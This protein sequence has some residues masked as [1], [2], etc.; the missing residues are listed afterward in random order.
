MRWFMTVPA[1]SGLVAQAGTTGGFTAMVRAAYPM[2]YRPA[3]V[4]FHALQYVGGVPGQRVLISDAGGQVWLAAYRRQEHVAGHGASTGAR[5]GLSL[6]RATD[7]AGYPD[8]SSCSVLLPGNP[9][10]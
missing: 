8:R 9:G 5:C 10:T 4:L 2:A 1:L 3:S 6:A 7:P